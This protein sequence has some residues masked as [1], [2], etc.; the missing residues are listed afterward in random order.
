MEIGIL[1]IDILIIIGY[2]VLVF[3]IGFLIVRNIKIG[4]DLFLGGRSFGWGLIGLFFFVFN[5]LSF[6]IIG[7]FGV[8]YIIGIVNLVYEWMLGIFLILVV[9]IFIFLY[10]CFR[11][12]IIFEYFE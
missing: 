12:I 7:L 11:I 9:M 1:G 2:F 5:I 10:L 3:I 8:V 4:E 6:I